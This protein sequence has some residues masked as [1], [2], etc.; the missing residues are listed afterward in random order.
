[1]SKEKRKYIAT[2]TTILSTS[3]SGLPKWRQ[4]P[5]NLCKTATWSKKFPP[6]Y[7]TNYW[8]NEGTATMT[9]TGKTVSIEF[10][11]R[12]LPAM[13]GGPLSKDVFQFVNVEFR[14]GPE[15]SSGA[16]HSINGIWLETT[17]LTLG[18]HRVSRRC[19]SAHVSSHSIDRRYSMEAQITHWNTRYGSI[20]KCFDK[21]DG[22]AVLSYL[23]QVIGCPGIPD[24][25]SLTKITNNLT[26]IKRMGSSTKIPPDCLLWMLEACRAHGYYTY[27]GS[28][29]VPPYSECVIWIISSTIT[30]ISTHQI[31]AFRNLYDG[32][33]KNI[34]G[35]CRQQQNL[36]RRRILFAT[37]TAVT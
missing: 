36:H 13:R 19:Y 23:M 15:N 27:P 1:M 14:W 11:D 5:I 16:E 33:W 8:S 18:A 10:S 12:T 21:P 29:T 9:N 32:K 7:M 3:S 26:N 20:E 25:P 34:S 37:D 30:K 31:D 2:K 4:S 22:I 17:S 28:L 35:N 24:N 6:L